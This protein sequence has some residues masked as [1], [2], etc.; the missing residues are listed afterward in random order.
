MTKKIDTWFPK[1]IY[2]AKEILLD[3]LLS[4]ETEIKKTIAEY[5][6]KKDNM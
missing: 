4:Y 6:S 1:S 3:K 2:D 5:A